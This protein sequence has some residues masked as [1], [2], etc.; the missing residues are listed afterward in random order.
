MWAAAAGR[1]VT[2]TYTVTPVDGP[3]VV[4]GSTPRAGRADRRHTR[5]PSTERRS[6]PGR[7]PFS[8]AA[9]A[10]QQGAVT[11]AVPAPADTS[12][13]CELSAACLL[14]TPCH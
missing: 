7:R 5:Q 11:T 14:V 4:V 10:L 6:S 13:G 3:A 1:C 9:P 8:G 2:R 12:S